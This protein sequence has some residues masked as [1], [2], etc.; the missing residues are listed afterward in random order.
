MRSGSPGGCTC[1]ERKE[2]FLGTNKINSRI[3]SM[4]TELT[5]KLSGFPTLTMARVQRTLGERTRREDTVPRRHAQRS[6]SI[7]VKNALRFNSTEG[8]FISNCFRQA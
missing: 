8:C 7:L 1:A 3:D 2:P 4:V 5:A 6:E